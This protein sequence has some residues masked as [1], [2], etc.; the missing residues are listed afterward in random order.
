M[1]LGLWD[2]FGLLVGFGP[3][4]GFVRFGWFWAVGWLW[5]F[6]WFWVFGWLGSLGLVLRLWAGFGSW[7]GFGFLVGFVPFAGF[8]PKRLRLIGAGARSWGLRGGLG[9]GWTGWAASQ[10]CNTLKRFQETPGRPRRRPSRRLRGGP[11]RTV[12]LQDRVSKLRF[13]PNGTQYS[14]QW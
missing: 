13:A 6:G 8:G 1:V 14:T 11:S 4:A 9:L 7:V 12:G 10:P 3:L 5:A 2:G